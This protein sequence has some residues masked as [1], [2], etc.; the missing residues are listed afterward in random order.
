MLTVSKAVN[1]WAK[2]TNH[3]IEQSSYRICFNF[4]GLN[5]CGLWV[6]AI[7]AFLC[8]QFL[9]LL[10]PHSLCHWGGKNLLRSGISHRLG[11]KNERT[12]ILKLTI[13]TWT[14]R[15]NP[16]AL[17]TFLSSAHI[18]SS[19]WHQWRFITCTGISSCTRTVLIRQGYRMNV[20]IFAFYDVTANQPV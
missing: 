17:Q 1:E 11:T 14:R 13:N 9:R 7:F 15:N 6:Y 20:T 3:H 2:C 8:S 19:P 16:T 12:D 10:L 5:F 18:L 4:A